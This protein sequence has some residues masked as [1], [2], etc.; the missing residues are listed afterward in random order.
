MLD[1][2]GLL[3]VHPLVLWLHVEKS[4]E[5]ICLLRDN[6]ASNNDDKESNELTEPWTWINVSI[7]YRDKCDNH[8]IQCIVEQKESVPILKYVSI[9]RKVWVSLNVV[10][11]EPVLNFQETSR[12][13]HDNDY[14]LDDN[15][16]GLPV[17]VSLTE[18]ILMVL[19]HY[20]AEVSDSDIPG[21]GNE[22][23]VA[24]EHAQVCH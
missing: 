17:H 4:K 21:D 23:I 6:N 7:A 19:E 14:K 24:A 5:L 1:V 16:F 10:K 13:Q 2:S 15:N 12:A 3:V 11:V 22:D 9:F 18:L 8:K 20:N